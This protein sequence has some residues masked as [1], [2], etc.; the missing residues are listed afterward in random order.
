[1][2]VFLLPLQTFE[3]DVQ[4]QLE[5]H[6]LDANDAVIASVLDERMEV[7]HKMARKSPLGYNQAFSSMGVGGWM[8]CDCWL[9]PRCVS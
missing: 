6:R 4:Y 8:G 2:L 1:M 3:F 7:V 5:Q 9:H